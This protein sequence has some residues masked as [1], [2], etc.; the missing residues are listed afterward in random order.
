MPSNV[1]SAKFLDKWPNGRLYKH[2]AIAL[3][4]R[5]TP[6]SRVS[7]IGEIELYM[8]TQ[9]LVRTEH[10]HV[11]EWNFRPEYGG[12]LPVTEWINSTLIATFVSDELFVMAKLSWD[13][14]N[15]D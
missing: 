8:Q 12:T 15:D 9:D 11:P 2:G 10:Y 4:F 7:A 14:I 1:I 3:T 13:L 5:Y 6:I